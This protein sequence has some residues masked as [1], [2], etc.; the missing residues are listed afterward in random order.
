MPRFRK[1]TL[2]GQRTPQCLED[3]FRDHQVMDCSPSYD[4]CSLGQFETKSLSGLFRKYDDGS[5]EVTLLKSTLY[6]Y[7][8]CQII[9]RLYGRVYQIL[10][11]LRIPKSQSRIKFLFYPTTTSNIRPRKLPI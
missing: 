5:L 10:C 11:T 9:T 6:I 8:H 1:K 2:G 3:L 4:V 7:E